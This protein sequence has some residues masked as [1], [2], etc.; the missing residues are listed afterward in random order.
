MGIALLLARIVLSALF[1]LAGIAKLADLPGSRKSL[2]DFGLASWL[3]K[4]FG[5]LLPLV[6]LTVG[7]LLLTSRGAWWGACV[8]VGLLLIFIAAISFNLVLGRAPDCHC[9]GQ[10]HSKPVGWSTLLRDAL[11]T[12]M[13][14]FILWQG[15]ANAS[16]SLASWNDGLPR[17]ES[18]AFAAAVIILSGLI[19]IGWLLLNLMS[20]NGRLLVRLEALEAQVQGGPA[21]AEKSGSQ[22]QNGLLPGSR[23]P[24]FELTSLTQDRVSLEALR[25]L[26]KPVLLLFT[27]P[28]CGPCRELMPEV[29]RWQSDHQDKLTVAVLT[30]G[31]QRRDPAKMLRY[32]VTNFLL[33]EDRE[34]AEEYLANG[35]PSAVLV[36][37]DGMIASYVAFGSKAI[38]D[39]VQRVTVPPQLTDRAVPP[40]HRVTSSRQ[41]PL[42]IGQPA[43]TFSLPDLSD[44]QFSSASLK[45]R[46]MLILFWNPGCGFCQ[47]MLPDLK[48][49]ESEQSS[50]VPQLIL[51]SSGSAEANRAMG[52]RSIILLDSGGKVARAF[53]SSGTPSAVLLNPENNIASNM[54]VG[55]PDVLALARS[56]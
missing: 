25:K 49:W 28:N 27:D 40:H 1:L 32:G 39:L 47:R 23:A 42:P 7:I 36:R 10:L 53:G 30:T 46:R 4:P 34:V 11:L 29:K 31:K 35:T 48:S 54:A 9:F 18:I 8:A 26:G 45:G 56:R 19:I 3:A 41:H 22:P 2:E 12:A 24:Q 33:Q 52:L 21:A 51:V 13:G 6:E 16:P 55:A 37:P 15:R 14:V 20:Q 44:R 17:T 50:E 43:P 38:I 5:F